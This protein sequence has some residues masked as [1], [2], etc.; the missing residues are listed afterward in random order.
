M[1]KFI[2]IGIFSFVLQLF[3]KGQCANLSFDE[4]ETLWNLKTKKEKLIQLDFDSLSNHAFGRCKIKKYSVEDT[5]CREYIEY[6]HFFTGDLLY[7]TVN[8]N[9]YSTL[10]STVLKKSKY[11][12]YWIFLHAKRE[13]YF[14]GSKYYAF[15]I[16]KDYCEKFKSIEYN[17][18]IYEEKPGYLK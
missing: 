18:K 14:D 17:I 4:L 9:I 3:T 7:S 2:L 6:V 5:M 12:G 16:Q 15:Y 13:F 8:G 11:I 10:K 1:L